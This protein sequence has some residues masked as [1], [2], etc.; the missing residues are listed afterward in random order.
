MIRQLMK[1]D[2]L[3]GSVPVLTLGSGAF[4]VLWHFLATSA[5]INPRSI[6]VSVFA[7]L[8][9]TVGVLA[10]TQQSD[11]LFQAALPVTVRQVY[12]ARILSMLGLLWLPAA[13]SLVI[14]LAL[15]NPA[16]PV[17]TLVEFL[18]VWTVAMVGIQSAGIHGFTMPKLMISVYF[19]LWMSVPALPR[20]PA[21]C[22]A[23]ILPGSFS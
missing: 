18:S 19:F 17:A 9:V 12:L 7:A 23:K 15:P 10:A 11:T 16:A 2:L 14:V 8:P 22:P 4:C 3:W 20:Y 21:G 6:F 13:V 5:N 1:R